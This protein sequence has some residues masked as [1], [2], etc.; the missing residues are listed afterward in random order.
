M[1]AKMAVLPSPVPT[2]HSKRLCPSANT[3]DFASSMSSTC[4]E[5]YRDMHDVQPRS[6]RAGARDG[7]THL[8]R[9][10]FPCAQGP[11]HTRETQVDPSEAWVQSTKH[12]C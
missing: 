11:S 10:Q 9:P 12:G 3:L 6:G 7:C 4:S 5:D 2:M 1:L 8:V